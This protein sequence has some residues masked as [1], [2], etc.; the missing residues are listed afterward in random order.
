MSEAL[1]N[2]AKLRNIVDVTEP[3]FGAKGDGITDDTEA[4]LNASALGLPLF[5]P[6]GIYILS[7]CNLPLNINWIGTG[8]ETVIKWKNNS[9]ESNLFSLSGIVNCLFSNLVFNANRQNQTDSTGY[10][11]TFGGTLGNGSKIV[12]DS[13]QFLNGRISDIYL[14]GP[15]GTG[16]YAE[17]NI[18]NCF[19]FDGLVGDITRAAQAVSVS[20]GIRLR[21][22]FNTLKQP[23]LPVVYG[24]GGIVMQRPGGST[25]LSWGQYEAIGNS[26]ENFGRQTDNRLGCLYVYSGSENTTI[27]Q[28]RFRNSVGSAITV[29]SDCGIT[30]VV[31]NVVNGHVDASIAAFSFFDQ[32]DVYTTSLGR[33]LVIADNAIYNPQ[34]ASIF[35]DGARNGFADF[36]NV[37]ITNNICD[38]G[39]RGIHFRNIENLKICGNLISQTTGIGIFGEDCSG[40]VDISLNNI[41]TG[42]VGID[43]NG[44]T[45]SAR[46]IYSDNKLSALTG[47]ALRIRSSVESFHISG[48]KIAGCTTVF[49]TRGATQFSSITGNLSR[50]DTSAW[51][52]TGAYGLLLFARNVT[53]TALTFATRTLTVAGGVI[54]AFGEWHYVDTEAAAATDDVDTINGGYEGARL[55]LFAAN[56]ARDVV[57]KDA[58]GNLRLAGDFTLTNSED[59]IDLMYVGTVWREMSRSDNTA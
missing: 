37:S 13:C 1:N 54:T 16:E 7:N 10:Y 22:N 57:L 26:F 24:R 4:I 40:D 12:F 48:N 50:G 3:R 34:F 32:A 23:T 18:K 21:F 6:K 47:S 49:D 27:S 17:V 59:S 56:N 33:S 36:K 5:F 25:S 51:D 44:V 2:A 29:K 15:T 53:T 45:S 8:S 41:S 11:G 43:I 20:E 58:T 31:G 30:S 14:T 38:G 55:V 9:A 42:L 39:V 28:N 35:V 19:F 52:K 46:V